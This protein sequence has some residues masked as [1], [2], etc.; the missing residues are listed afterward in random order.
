MRRIE[1]ELAWAA[2]VLVERGFVEP[3]GRDQVPKSEKAL[4]EWNLAY[5]A[6]AEAWIATDPEWRCI[7]G[8]E[9]FAARLIRAGVGIQLAAMAVKEGIA[10]IT[11]AVAIHNWSVVFGATRVHLREWLDGKPQRLAAQKERARK[12]KSADWYAPVALLIKQ[13]LDAGYKVEA[14]AEE[15]RAKLIRDRSFA[16]SVPSLDAIRVKIQRVRKISSL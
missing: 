15:A 14:I 16:A 4:M 3:T 12:L 8:P 2:G 10:P 9:R 11:S 5:S 13:G 1:A 6:A 7:G